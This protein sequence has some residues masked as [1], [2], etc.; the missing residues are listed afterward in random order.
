MP[1]KWTGR[2]IDHRFGWS[3]GRRPAPAV[4]LNYRGTDQP[5]AAILLRRELAARLG[6]HR[7]FLDSTSIHPGE[8]F[9][10]VVTAAVTGCRVLLAVIG[11]NWLDVG[12]NGHRPID[13]ERDWVRREILLALA[14]R[15]RVIPILVDDTPPPD[16]ERLPPPMAA[17]A[18]CQYLRLRHRDWHQDLTLLVESVVRLVGPLDAGDRARPG[19]FPL[20]GVA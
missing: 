20:R 8:D 19:R 9:H 18:R 10:R 7:V 16:V 17:L 12:P 2:W 3:V 6:E 1:R 4:F 15:V 13:D 14:T 11:H 5:F